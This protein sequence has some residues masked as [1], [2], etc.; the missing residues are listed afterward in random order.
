MWGRGGVNVVLVKTV[1]AGVD[2][3]G[4]GEEGSGFCFVSCVYKIQIASGGEGS[5]HGS[6][7]RDWC[8]DETSPD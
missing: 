5:H 8:V 7:A 3:G 6:R 2:G 1:L 4:S